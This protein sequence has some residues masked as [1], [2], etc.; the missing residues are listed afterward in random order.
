MR[1]LG[2]YARQLSSLMFPTVGSLFEDEHGYYVGECLSPGHVLQ[3][4]ETIEDI[5]RG[6]FYNEADYYSS[7][8]A[9]LR[10]HVE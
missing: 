7:L 1:Q 10:L 9:A 3:D 2:C 6:P 8:A 4:R 5:P